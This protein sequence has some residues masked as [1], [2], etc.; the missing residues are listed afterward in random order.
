MIQGDPVQRYEQEWRSRS[1]AVADSL[2]A[3]TAALAPRLGAAWSHHVIPTRYRWSHSDDRVWER[4][5]GTL[6]RA[7]G[8][9]G[10]HKLARSFLTHAHGLQ[11][12]L[13]ERPHRVGEF[14]VGAMLPAGVFEY[15]TT[16]HP[17]AIAVSGDPVRAGAAV[18]RRLLPYYR[19]AALRVA[20]GTRF[21]QASRVVIGRSS[22]GRPIAD[23]VMPRAIRVL[24]HEDGRWRLDPGTGLCVTDIKEPVAPEVLVQDAGDRLRQLG[25]EVVLTDRNPLE[26]HFPSHPPARTA[27]VA[28]APPPAPGKPGRAR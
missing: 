27:P 26:I 8:R 1:A 5:E 28:A 17:K 22:N 15:D 11:L 13:I 19:H 12:C 21:K 20:S 14:L 10:D 9:H 16:D 23:A 4:E 2:E 24:L 7:L 25:F 18:R 3:F 6:W